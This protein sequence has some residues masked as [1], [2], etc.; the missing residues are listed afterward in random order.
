VSDVDTT[1]GGP[2]Q[3]RPTRRLLLAGAVA[4]AL[5]AALTVTW[6][7]AAGGS[8]TPAPRGGTDVGNTVLGYGP[9]PSAAVGASGGASGS[10]AAQPTGSPGP[11][12]PLT[13]PF[14][15]SPSASPQPA[16][17]SPTGSPSQKPVNVDGC[18]HNYGPVN[19]CVPWT[20]PAGITDKCGWLRQHGYT[21]P[22][23]VHGTD[24]QG[25]D[26]NRDGSACG[27]GD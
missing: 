12:S 6:V 18:D 27:T 5:L 2:A 21:L 25:L 1:A 19:V 8:G 15:T 11:P 13:Q 3:R 23:A 16:L 20:F 26:T 14:A 7:L 4:V 24:R 10:A 9:V 17:P 22:L